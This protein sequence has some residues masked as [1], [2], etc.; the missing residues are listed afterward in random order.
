MGSLAG[1][2]TPA[3]QGVAAT[4]TGQNGLSQG[5]GDGEAM[6]C[7]GGAADTHTVHPKNIPRTTSP[8]NGAR[9]RMGTSSVEWSAATSAVLANA[10]FAV[11]GVLR[12]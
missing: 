10:G 8:A 5:G 7:G 12:L 6:A 3:F 9:D 2:F 11:A 4:E 1:M